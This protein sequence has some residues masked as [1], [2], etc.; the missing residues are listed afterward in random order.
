MYYPPP[1]Q[2]KVWHYQEADAILIRRIIYKFYWKRA[3]SNLIVD[4]QVTLFNRTILN[5]MENFMT[6][7]TIVCDDRDGGM[8]Q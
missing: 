2:R 3:L 1:Y 6:H 5:I 4:E 8:V 7:E